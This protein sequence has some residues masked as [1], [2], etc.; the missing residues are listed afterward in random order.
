LWQNLGLVELAD[1]HPRDARRLFLNSLDAAR[2]TGTKSAYFQGALLGLALTVGAD[3]DPAVAATLHGVADEHYERA[4]RVFGA[5]GARLRDRDHAHLC[6]TLGDAAF[7]SAYRRGRTLSEADAIALA[8]TAAEPDPEVAPAVTV[9]ASRPAPADSQAGRLSGK[10]REVMALLA[11]GASNAEIAETLYMTVNTVRTH[12]DRIR[13]KT[14]I[15]KR[16][17]LTRYAIAAG[18]ERSPLPPEGPSR[19]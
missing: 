12:L 6:A 7:E 2:T 13:D 8:T 18:I 5:S 1:G 14:G 3:G 16:V 17:E 11:R 4:G 9:P 15:R 19:P 10:E